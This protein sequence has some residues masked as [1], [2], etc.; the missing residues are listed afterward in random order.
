[1]GVIMSNIVKRGYVST[2]VIEFNEQSK[3]LLDQ[4]QRDL[5]YL[6]NQGY[7][8]K[9]ASTFIGNHYLLSERQRLALVRATSSTETLIMRKQKLIVRNID[10]QCVHIDALNL[11]IT[12]EVALS[13]STLLWC[14]DGT[15]RD[16][17][18]LRGTY[19]L[20]DKTDIA[21]KLIGD[22]LK[23]KKVKEAVFYLDSPVSNT[24]RLKQRLLE[25]L[26]QYPYSVKV[27]LVY[28]ADVILE[29]KE[30]VITSDAIILNKCISWINLASQIVN[31][32]IPN[33]RCLD[34]RMKDSSN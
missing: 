4:A 12:L 33:A 15:I 28:N 14:M 31:D 24:G 17:A 16:L 26:G 9:S 25:I 1:M 21:I 23:E 3:C 13:E 29:E 19:R 22:K 18:G 6:L 32:S 2:D 20:I 11:I 5:F 27:E 7:P 8:I 10:N 34:F 30:N